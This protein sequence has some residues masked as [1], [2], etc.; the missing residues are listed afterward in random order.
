MRKPLAITT[1]GSLLIWNAAAQN[2]VVNGG[3]ENPTTDYYASLAPGSIALTGWTIDA[4]PPPA[5][6]SGCG[7]GSV[8]GGVAPI[9]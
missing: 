5:W 1:L 8:H 4:T 2:L 7:G 6:T 3:F 9:I